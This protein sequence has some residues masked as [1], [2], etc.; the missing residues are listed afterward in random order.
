VFAY[1]DESGNTGLKLFDEQQPVLLTLTL[2]SPCEVDSVLAPRHAEWLAA[3]GVPR[4]HANELG[5]AKLEALA[6]SARQFIELV[7]PR[8]ILTFIH[9]P[10]FGAVK[11]VDTILD[12]GINNA[13]TPFH[14]GLRAMRLP[15]ALALVQ[16]M[17]PGRR[18]RLLGGMGRVGCDGVRRGSSKRTHER[19]EASRSTNRSVA[20]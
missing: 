20:R 9:K 10:Y 7:D 2:V 14:Y 13:V 1:T 8:F 5:L 4:L 15:L 18:H 16:G 17:E 3:L 12:N 6:D 11:F 19:A